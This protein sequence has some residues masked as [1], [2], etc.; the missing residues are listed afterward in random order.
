MADTAR[1]AVWYFTL[2]YHVI[3]RRVQKAENIQD[4]HI[5][6]PGDKTFGVCEP[7][8]EIES[9][10]KTKKRFT[11]R[12]IMRRTSLKTIKKKKRD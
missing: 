4:I 11:Q 10:F 6:I 7:E 9:C 5:F 12:N 3:H 1:T 8:N 2:I